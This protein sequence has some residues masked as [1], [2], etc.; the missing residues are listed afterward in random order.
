[1][2][3]VFDCATAAAAATFTF[4]YFALSSDLLLARV[5]VYGFDA[6]EGG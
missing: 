2:F 6:V 4:E 1:M 5:R 3:L